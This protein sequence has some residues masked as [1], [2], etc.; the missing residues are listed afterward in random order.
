MVSNGYITR[1]HGKCV[2][3]QS[4]RSYTPVTATVCRPPQDAHTT[5]S[6]ISTSN[7]SE[8]NIPSP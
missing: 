2:S 3:R 4:L 7:G 8:A 6:D 5:L 1:L